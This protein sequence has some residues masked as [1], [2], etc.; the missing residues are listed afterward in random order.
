MTVPKTVV[1]PLHHRAIRP[2]GT[3]NIVE[4]GKCKKTERKILLFNIHLK[5][6][7]RGFSYFRA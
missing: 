3:A 1:L 2:F 6:E 5:A 4:K 7:G